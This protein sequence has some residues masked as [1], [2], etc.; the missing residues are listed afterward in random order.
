MSFENWLHFFARTLSLLAMSSNG[1]SDF[2]IEPRATSPVGTGTDLSRTADLGQRGLSGLVEKMFLRRDSS[3]SQHKFDISD[4]DQVS[5]YDNYDALD[6]HNNDSEMLTNDDM[7]SSTT[8]LTTTFALF[9]N[10]C[11]LSLCFGLDD[12]APLRG[13][14]STFPSN[15]HASHKMARD[16]ESIS[17]VLG[18]PLPLFLD[19]KS[20]R[21]PPR[22]WLA[23]IDSF[24]TRG[25]II[26][27]INRI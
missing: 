7:L 21:V 6:F 3:Y 22:V 26:D 1:G 16:I 13:T 23:L 20:R 8:S 19:L 18:E 24:C 14:Q 9:E 15:P 25:L 2:D 4:K 27:R 5:N 11:G 10:C 17:M 12:T